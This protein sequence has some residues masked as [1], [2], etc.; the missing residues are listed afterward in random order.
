MQFESWF[1]VKIV[2]LVFSV[3]FHE[4]AH[5]FVAM[6]CGDY[7][8]KYAGR[9][10]FNPIPHIDVFGTIILPLLLILTSS[11]FLLG[12]AKPVPV[13]PYNYRNGRIDDVK[14]SAAGPGSNLLLA[15][16]FTVLALLIAWISPGM[17]SGIWAMIQYGILINIV[18]A[19]FNLMPIPPLDGSHIVA[20][21][22]PPALALRYQQIQQYGLILVFIFIMT[23]LFRIVHYIVYFVYGIYITILEL[24]L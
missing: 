17:F 3:I 16:G 23:P 20:F 2:I 8:A 15:F 13:N 12:W 10:T 9:L 5:G 7:T 14:V 11:Q 24:F 22:L 21:F 18:L 19:V 1:G 4:V 6:K